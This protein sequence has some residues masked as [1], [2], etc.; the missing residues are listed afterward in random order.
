MHKA[1]LFKE[2]D[3]SGNEQTILVYAAEDTVSGIIYVKMFRLNLT[4]GDAKYKTGNGVSIDSFSKA[5][6]DSGIPMAPG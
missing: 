3:S 2:K 5:M 6:W 4:Q 1:L